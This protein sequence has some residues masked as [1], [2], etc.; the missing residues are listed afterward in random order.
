M[1]IDQ[2]AESPENAMAYELKFFF[3]GGFFLGGVLS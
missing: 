1:H 3:F 2:P